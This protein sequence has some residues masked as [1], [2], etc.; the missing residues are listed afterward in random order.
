MEF[1]QEKIGVLQVK[2]Y[3][4]VLVKC[5]GTLVRVIDNLVIYCAELID[6][7]F[8]ES[9]SNFLIFDV[10]LALFIPLLFGICLHYLLYLLLDYHR[11]YRFL[12]L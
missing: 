9:G 5:F 4:I 1:G 10:F 7:L 6:D 12:D 3:P 2:L 11:F 8:D